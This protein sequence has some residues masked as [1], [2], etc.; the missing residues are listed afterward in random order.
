MSY[1]SMYKAA[2]KFAKNC[3]ADNDPSIPGA[4]PGIAGANYYHNPE[5]PD[6]VLRQ[7]ITNG[8]YGVSYS[9]PLPNLSEAPKNNAIPYEKMCFCSKPE[10]IRDAYL[11]GYF[12]DYSELKE[13]W[14]KEKKRCVGH[15]EDRNRRWRLAQGEKQLDSVVVDIEY[16]INLMEL[17]DCSGGEVFYWFGMINPVYNHRLIQLPNGE[18]CIVDGVI[19]PIRF[20]SYTKC[21][22]DKPKSTMTFLWGKTS[23][24]FVN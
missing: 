8:Y 5:D 23:K 24:D 2:T 20:D 16:L 9:S 18:R 3:H 21:L 15:P 11:I 6:G 1:N 14:K 13:A 4:R 12:P 22:N 17:T 10:E 19:L 7:Y